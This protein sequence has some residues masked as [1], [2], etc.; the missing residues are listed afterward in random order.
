MAVET[1]LSPAEVVP[2]A[3]A[4][5]EAPASGTVA[6]SAIPIPSASPAPS[7]LAQKRVLEEDHT[8]RPSIPS[9]LNPDAGLRATPKLQ[10]EMPAKRTKKDTLKKREASKAFASDERT[11]TPDSKRREARIQAPPA[12]SPL[13]Y[14]QP[15][16][17]PSDFNPPRGP[18]FTHHRTTVGPNGQGSIDFYETTD[19]LYNKKNF[20]YTSCIADPAFP[21]SLLFR[22]TETE[23][24]G[25]HLQFEDAATHMFFDKSGRHVTTDKGFRMVR[26]N[27]AIREGRF[28]WEVKITRGILQQ[29]NENG[30]E[31]H[32]HVR[33]GFARREAAVDAPV[34]FDCYSYGIRDKAGQKVFMSR[35]KAFFPDSEDICEG[36][37]VGLEIQLP[38]VRL[39]NKILAGQYNPA[40]DGLDDPLPPGTPVEAPNIV[41]DR[42][43]IS[44]RKRQLYFEQITYHPTKELEDLM[45]TGLDK[46]ASGNPVEKPHPNHPVHALR[47]LPNSYIKVYKNGKYMGTAFEDLLAFLP[48]ASKPPAIDGA[49][50][51]L[52][53]GMLGY[54][55]AVSV[56]RGG[57]AEVNFGPDFWFPPP[58]YHAQ[59][60][61]GHD[62]TMPDATADSGEQAS[63]PEAKGELRPVSE[64]Y[65]EQI[66]EDVVY[67]IIDEVDY[68]IQDGEKIIDQSGVDDLKT[69]TGQESMA[70]GR[71]EIKE[72]EQED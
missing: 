66:A 42:A 43:P 41:R 53:D 58:G 55:P 68:W 59:S 65:L 26:A 62:V 17:K 38:S 13:R 36:D 14:K 71:E 63:E 12:D 39:H 29:K 1:E 64:R 72:V 23:P 6:Q 67:D 44:F 22:Q 57:A 10:D 60:S 48:P 56:F 51:G 45:S 69:A 30:E 4:P 52:D 21:S 70:P 34:G 16:P 61:P 35:P 54:V 25:P 24:Y 19:Q 15:P 5:P 50:P 31:S 32:G 20:R 8:P 37:V 27:V 7:G 49:R 46:T 9:P 33:L 47:T 40:V 2:G 18:V 28:F 11:S 3:S